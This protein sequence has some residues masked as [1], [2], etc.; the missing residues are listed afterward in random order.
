MNRKYF[1]NK[2][3]FTIMLISCL[4]IF[5]NLIVIDTL[6]PFIAKTMG[7]VCITSFGMWSVK[8]IWELK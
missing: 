4:I 5:R 6:T 8:S 1:L 2:I 3:L 7:I